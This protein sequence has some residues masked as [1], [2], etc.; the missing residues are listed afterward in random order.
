MIPWS[1]FP[2]AYFL[3]LSDVLE[4][5]SGLQMVVVWLDKHPPGWKSPH[6]WSES[7][8][9]KLTTICDI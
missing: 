5:L 3:G 8:A 6:Y 2:V 9:I 4:C 7:L 1:A